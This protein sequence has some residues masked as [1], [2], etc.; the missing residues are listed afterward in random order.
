VLG[1]IT[2][3][4]LPTIATWIV[5]LGVPYALATGFVVGLFDLIPLV[6]ATLGAIFVG[7]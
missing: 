3:S 2:I 7:S 5:L 1:N 6:G 4:V